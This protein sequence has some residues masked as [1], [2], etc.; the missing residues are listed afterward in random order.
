VG[1]REVNHGFAISTE[2]LRRD[3]M[4]TLGVCGMRGVQTATQEARSSDWQARYCHER[5]AGTGVPCPYVF[6]MADGDCMSAA[7][8]LRR[9]YHGLIM[10]RDQKA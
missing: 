5:R 8:V 7:M 2:V 9:C 1:L 4:R 3:E 10:K 6:A